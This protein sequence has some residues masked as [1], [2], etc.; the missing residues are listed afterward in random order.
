MSESKK[1]DVFL[2][3]NSND[4]PQVEEIGI[5]LK[6]RGLKPWLDKWELRPGL[7][8]QPELERQIQHINAAAVCIGNN[9]LGPWQDLEIQAFLRQFVNRRCP[10]IPVLLDKVTSEF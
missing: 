7:P 2:C 5:Q 10:V 6:T 9:A 1:F 4:K 3:H 8:W